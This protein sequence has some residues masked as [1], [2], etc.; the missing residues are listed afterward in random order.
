VYYL[1]LN[2]LYVRIIAIF[3]TIST[4][5]M[6]LRL[7]CYISLKEKPFTALL[8]TKEKFMSNFFANYAHTIIF[9][10]V[11]SAIIWIGGMIAI[12]LAVHP[13]LQLIEDTKLKLEK[14]LSIMG[15]FFNIVIPFIIIILITAI[16]MSMGMQIQNKMF[17]YI[18]EAIWTVMAINFIV[19]YLKRAKAQKFF[20][21]NKIGD[22]KVT[23]AIIPK[24]LL[25]LNIIL[26]VIAL[27]F[28]VS[29]RGF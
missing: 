16:I 12:R 18:K 23:L 6:N 21:D 2:Y 24:V 15:R 5:K 9:L 11:L 20:E 3:F 1:I 25:P 27:I 7:N 17:I 22:T 19:M 14:T 4:Q 28:G 13:H 8:R 26:G 29:L 10:H